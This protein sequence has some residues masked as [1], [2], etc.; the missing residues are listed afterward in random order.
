MPHGFTMSMVPSLD[1]P[2]S[3]RRRIKRCC[4]DADTGELLQ[5][6][7]MSAYATRYGAREGRAV[8]YAPRAAALRHAALFFDAHAAALFE[9]SCDAISS[10]RACC[11]KRYAPP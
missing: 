4:A 8:A 11:F 2:F 6:Q 5:V 1:A 10:A 3:S 7:L 9:N